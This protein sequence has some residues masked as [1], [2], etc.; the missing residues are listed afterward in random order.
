MI[1]AADGVLQIARQT[2]LSIYD[3]SYLEPAARSGVPLATLDR[4]LAS[5]AARVGVALLG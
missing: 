1:G 3:A 5:A 2:G 4:R